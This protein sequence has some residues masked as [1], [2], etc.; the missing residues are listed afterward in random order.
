MICQQELQSMFLL[1]TSCSK[2]WCNSWHPFLLFR[3]WQ[4]WK[5]CTH[6][7]LPP[8]HSPPAHTK[9]SAVRGRGHKHTETDPNKTGP[10]WALLFRR[11]LL[12]SEQCGSRQSSQL[13]PEAPSRTQLLPCMY[14]GCWISNAAWTETHH[15]C[16]FY[17]FLASACWGNAWHSGSQLD[18]SY[19]LQLDLNC[20]PAGWIFRWQPLEE[21][22]QQLLA[23]ML[24]HHVWHGRTNWECVGSLSSVS[25]RGLTHSL[26]DVL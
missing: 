18:I 9:A 5:W 24:K 16:L 2:V 23:E 19:W 3:A 20:A 15:W 21:Q 1:H 6:G 25:L 14:P 17:I 13:L 22:W 26:S 4:Q 11:G 12:F 10:G 8:H 7:A